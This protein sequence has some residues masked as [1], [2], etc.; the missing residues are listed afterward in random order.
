MNQSRYSF[1]LFA[2]WKE[3]FYS[4]LETAERSCAG[5]VC[6]HFPTDVFGR[7]GI[8]KGFDSA[9]VYRMWNDYSV[10]LQQ[11]G[12]WE[13]ICKF[14]KL[15]WAP[16]AHIFVASETCIIKTYRTICYWNNKYSDL[17]SVAPLCFPYLRKERDFGCVWVIILVKSFLLPICG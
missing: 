12:V 5:G 13:F 15:V 10:K 2:L 11:L 17:H 3:S 16:W 4:F 8:I 6:I 14:I 9:R 1:S 7:Y